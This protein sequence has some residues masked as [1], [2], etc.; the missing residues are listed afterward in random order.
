MIWFFFTLDKVL[1]MF[2]FGLETTNLW[3]ILLLCLLF[4]LLLFIQ[5]LGEVLCHFLLLLLLFRNQILWFLLHLLNFLIEFFLHLSF[6]RLLLKLCLDKTLILH[7]LDI[8][9]SL[10]E[11]V[12]LWLL[13]LFHLLNLALKLMHF[14][15]VINLI[16]YVYRNLLSKWLF[17]LFLQ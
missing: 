1:R 9:Y 2:Q 8:S 12:F 15:F 4:T 11:L 7:C 13:R 17:V 16:L 14:I 10:L 6:L 5:L 3:T